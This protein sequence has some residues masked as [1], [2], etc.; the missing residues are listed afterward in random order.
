[1]ELNLLEKQME[2]MFTIWKMWKR[3]RERE[4]WEQMN[5]LNCVWGIRLRF[6]ICAFEPLAG[7]YVVVLLYFLSIYVCFFHLFPYFFVLR[8]CTYFCFSWKC[9]FIRW[10]LLICFNSGREHNAEQTIMAEL[11]FT[12]ENKRIIETTFSFATN[13][14]LWNRLRIYCWNI[15]LLLCL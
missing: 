6:W 13:V 7:S 9:S 11:T 2:I 3:K 5:N 8:I 15:P 12:C 10:L 14:E 1:M 4:S